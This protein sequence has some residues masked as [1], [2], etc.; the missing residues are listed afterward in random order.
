MPPFLSRAV[1]AKKVFCPF[2]PGE[3]SLAVRSVKI[4]DK[5]LI[6]KNQKVFQLEIPV[7]EPL[8]MELP[9]KNACVSDRVSFVE[10][11]FRR[12]SGFHLIKILDQVFG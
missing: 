9:E 1:E 10:E 7:V 5:N 12:N 6:S 2:R 8:F 11:F 3:G 4:D